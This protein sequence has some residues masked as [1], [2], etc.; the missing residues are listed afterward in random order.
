MGID[1]FFN[2]PLHPNPKVYSYMAI[3][4]PIQMNYTFGLQGKVDL[5]CDWMGTLGQH[6]NQGWR[7]ADIFLV[8]GNDTMSCRNGG[9]PVSQMNSVWFFEKERS[10]LDDPTPLYEGTYVEYHVKVKVGFGSISSDFNISQLCQDMGNRGWKLVC[11]IDTPIV[12]VGFASMKKAVMLFFER[13]IMS[14]T[15]AVGFA[16]PVYTPSRGDVPPPPYADEK[17]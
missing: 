13:R 16:A 12:S 8:N 7:L 2:M 9:L 15:P 4:V 11:F 5:L 6:L 10:R 14:P 17:D 3:S 1:L